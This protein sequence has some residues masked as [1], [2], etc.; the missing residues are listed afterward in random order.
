MNTGLRTIARFFLLTI[1]LC[2]A[3]GCETPQP[4]PKKP[5]GR[6]SQVSS[7]PWN[8]PAKWEGP[9]SMGGMSPMAMQ[10]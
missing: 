8:R 6:G 3:A 10:Q 1:M 5:E 9:A 7:I 2:L 4:Q